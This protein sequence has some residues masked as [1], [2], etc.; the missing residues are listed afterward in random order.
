MKCKS[1]IFSSKPKNISNNNTI[2]NQILEQ[3]NHL[4]D[5]ELKFD[6]TLS[7]KQHTSSFHQTEF[8]F[9]KNQ[10]S[11]ILKYSIYFIN[12]QFKL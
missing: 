9:L 1:F 7:L 10:M 11:K 12:I 4:A 5:F 3:V 2:N 8:V 6:S